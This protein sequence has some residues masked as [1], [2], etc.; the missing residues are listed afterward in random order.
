MGLLLKA[1]LFGLVI[2]YIFKS[3]GLVMARIMG[4]GPKPPDTHFQSRREGD[5]NVD[6][7][8]GRD[9]SSRQ[10]KKTDGDYIDYEEVK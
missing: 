9:G 6:Y 7:R 1:F 2:Y 10:N 4:A 5:I 8:P 3:I